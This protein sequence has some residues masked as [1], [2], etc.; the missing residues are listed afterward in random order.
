MS[1]AEKAGRAPARVIVVEDHPLVRQT[2]EEVLASVPGIVHA[3]SAHSAEE[4]LTLGALREADLVLI[5]VS[6]PSMTG[7][8]LVRRILLEH[9]RVLCAMLSGHAQDSYVKAALDAGARGYILKGRTDELLQGIAR[10][11][12]GEVYISKTLH[13]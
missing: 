3:A 1:T 12:A 4:A 5:D 11:L 2:L 7:L 9:P 8:E 10:I 6:L 13:K